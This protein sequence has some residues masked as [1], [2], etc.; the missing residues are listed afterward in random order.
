MLARM[1]EDDQVASPPPAGRGRLALVAAVAGLLGVVVGVVASA[2][3]W[4][5]SAGLPTR[6]I[7][8]VD[9]P[10][11]PDRVAAVAAVALPSVVR[12]D[13]AG[14]DEG[15]LGNGSGVVVTDQGHIVTNLHVVAGATRVEVVF[16]DGQSEHADVVGQD[17]DNDLAL[18]VTP[19]TDAP[20][21]DLADADALRVGQLAVAVGAPFGLDGTV[22]V[23][24]VSALERPIDLV[25]VDGTTV[26]LPSVLQTDAEINPGNSGGP[27]VDARGHMIGV[28]SAVLTSGTSSSS[29]VGFAI[30][31]DVVARTVEDLLADGAVRRPRLGITGRSLTTADLEAHG[32]TQGVLVEAVAQPSSAAMAGV[33]AGDVIVAVDDEPVATID[34]LVREVRAAGVGATIG[35]TR[36]TDDGEEVLAVVLRAETG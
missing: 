11:D 3:L 5:P 36:I 2:A 23:G 31:V 20:P 25:A 4:R 18:L 28:T 34:D 24:V 14:I 12:V 1:A 7:I 17:P 35:L 32:R 6:P 13:V 21:I 22:T 19:R 15:G 16:A 30:P 9:G 27:L 8:A 29:G 33:E 10:D 26:R